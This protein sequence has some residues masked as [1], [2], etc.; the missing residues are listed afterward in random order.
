MATLA[1]QPNKGP[2]TAFLTAT[3][4]E[5]MYGGAAGGGK[6][7]AI[8][9]MP[10]RRVRHP[11]HRSIILRRTR[12]QLQEVI[13]RTREL[14][15]TVWPG[16]QWRESESRWIWPSGAVTQMG[17]AEHE[18]DI[19]AFKT[20]EYDMVLFDELT[21][22]TEKQ[23]KF[24][25]TRNRSKSMDLPPVI[26][27]GTNPDDIGSAWVEQRFVTAR[28]PY[29]VYDRMVEL[30]NGVKVKTSQQFIPAKVWDNPKLPHRDEYIAGI[31]EMDEEDA[32]AYL[33]GQWSRT[34]GSM[35]KKPLITVPPLLKSADYYV[36][37]SMDYGWSDQ[38]A[39]YWL[40]VYPDDTVDI[41]GELYVN[42]T[43]ID[44]LAKLIKE[45]EAE[46][47]T[48]GVTRIAAQRWSVAGKDAFSTEGTSAQ[49]IAS[50]F[51]E[52][53]IVFTEANTDRA[54]GWTQVNRLLNR[55]ALRVWDGAAPNLVRTLPHL[56]RDPLKPTD[57]KKRQEDHPADSLRYG[58]LAIYLKPEVIP[59]PEPAPAVSAQNRDTVLE[60]WLKRSRSSAWNERHGVA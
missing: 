21:S 2:Q 34:A 18:P 60:E 36:V 20:F 6:T 39:I 16:A 13:D 14:Y 38:T 37:R 3:S 28:Y 10:F 26:R 30:P 9:A 23:Y 11:K 17:F 8:V 29:E 19:Y 4:R 15:P 57:I 44:G 33:L 53:H 12:R 47:V 1:W 43:T 55:A 46:L 7:D 27:S 41:V 22:F 40:L 5:V 42:Q 49:S 25:F 32:A 50:M 52:R 35:F 51:Q 24:M 45:K 48:K 59:P 54:A 31:M 56:K 58:L